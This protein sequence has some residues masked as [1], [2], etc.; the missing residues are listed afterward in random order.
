MND[1]RIKT[2]VQRYDTNSYTRLQ[3]LQAVSH[4]ISSYTDDMCDVADDNSSDDDAASD[5][6]RGEVQLS[7][8]PST[9]ATT[10]TAVSAH[11]DNCDVCLVAP[12]DPSIAWCLAATAV[13]VAHVLKRCTTEDSVVLCAEVRFKCCCVC[14]NC[15]SR[16]FRIVC[17]MCGHF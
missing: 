8:T 12:M 14:F 13:S 5:V 10:D 15:I 17:A 6:D 7:D 4:S 9:S 11:V 16:F 2:C 1:K 3:F